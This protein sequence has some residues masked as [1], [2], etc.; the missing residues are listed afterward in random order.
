MI[1]RAISLGLYMPHIYYANSDVCLFYFCHDSLVMSVSTLCRTAFS[2]HC[3]LHL[4]VICMVASWTTLE[5]HLHH[6]WLSL[7]LTTAT[8][9]GSGKVASLR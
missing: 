9:L 7:D 5:R 1:N 2:I 3:C 8:A 4:L 6:F